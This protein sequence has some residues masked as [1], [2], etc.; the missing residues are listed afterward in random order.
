MK[1]TEIADRIME[2]L[3]PA[4]PELRERWA[5]SAGTIHHCAIDNLLPDD[6]AHKIRDAYPSGGGMRTLKSLRELKHVAAQMNQYDP[7]LEESLYAFQDPRVVAAV[8]QITGLR[9]LEPDELLYAGGISVMS[10]G[11]FLNP[12][13]DNSHDRDRVRYRVLNLLYYV[14]PGWGLANGGNLEL[15][16]DGLDGKQVTI[17][18]RFNRLAIMITNKSSLHSVS[19]VLVDDQRCCVS[20]YYFSQF[21]AEKEDYFHVTSY[22]GRPEQPLRDLVLRGDAALRMGIRKVFPKGIVKNKHYYERD[23]PPEN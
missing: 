7:I 17:E 14:S 23:T 5:A 20:N 10:K 2:K 16:P 22:R 18:S 4:V 15:W 21:P 1:R 19:P 11:H 12:H 13:V 8:G 3:A 6:L 9:A